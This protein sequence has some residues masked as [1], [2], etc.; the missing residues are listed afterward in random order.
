MQISRPR[1]S[2]IE[3]PI[4]T[5]ISDLG[6]VVS[7]MGRRA[8]ANLRL[9]PTSGGQDQRITVGKLVAIRAESSLAIG[10]VA[11]VSET[12]DSATL[13]SRNVV[14]ADIDLLG[15]ILNYGAVDAYFQRGVSE[16]PM[17]GDK[18]LNLGTDELQVIHRITDAETID[19]EIYRTSCK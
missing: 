13:G 12:A 11:G 2:F 8:K 19:P 16:Y 15:E 14:S 7:V 5:M 3:G 4:A 9:A 18:L 6:A 10:V 17:I 1:E